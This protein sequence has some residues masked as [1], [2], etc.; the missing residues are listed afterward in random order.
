MEQH[1][2]WTVGAIA[3]HFGVPVHRVEYVVTSRRLEPQ[4]RAGVLRIFSV[5]DVEVIGEVLR[6][7]QQD[8]PRA[9]EVSRG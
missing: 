1:R 6:A 2:E 8:T 5:E 9:R 3:E 4:S 7:R